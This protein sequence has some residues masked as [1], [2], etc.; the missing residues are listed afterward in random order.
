MSPPSIRRFVSVFYGIFLRC[1]HFFLY[2][3][4]CFFFFCLAKGPFRDLF[5]DYVTMCILLG[6][7]E[8]IL[9]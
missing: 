8:Q 9:G 2:V 6:V 5:D 4:E 3:C 1:F 7:L